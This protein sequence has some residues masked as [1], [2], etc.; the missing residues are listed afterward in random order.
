MF[1]HTHFLPVTDVKTGVPAPLPPVL[2]RLSA[3]ASGADKTCPGRAG[4]KVKE[5]LGPAPL[6]FS[7]V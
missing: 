7:D 4:H 3:S 5:I 1:L 2:F 6:P